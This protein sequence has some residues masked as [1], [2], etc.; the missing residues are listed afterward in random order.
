[1]VK[2]DRNVVENLLNSAGSNI[3]ATSLLLKY[4]IKDEQTINSI[5][6]LWYAIEKLIRA[7]LYI[8]N[9]L[10]LKKKSTSADILLTSLDQK[11]FNSN[12]VLKL[13]NDS[14]SVKEAWELLL[15]ATPNL[16]L[17]SAYF[18]EGVHI[19]NDQTHLFCTRPPALTLKKAKRDA[20]VIIQHLC[21]S[22]SAFAAEK[23]ELKG[24]DCTA[25][26]LFSDPEALR[27]L[28]NEVQKFN[29]RHEFEIIQEENKKLIA[30]NKHFHDL[31]QRSD[32]VPV[33]HYFDVNCPV[34]NEPNGHVGISIDENYRVDNEGDEA[35]WEGPIHYEVYFENFACDHC[36]ACVTSL[37]VLS[38]LGYDV[39]LITPELV[40]DWDINEGVQNITAEY[41][42]RK[43]FHM[44]S[45]ITWVNA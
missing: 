28:E 39:D 8:I 16:K 5:C 43:G 22:I 27:E 14:I 23:Q 25:K 17:L 36:G 38:D 6:N 13:H 24:F 11:A 37:S 42:D 32:I 12:Y 2:I 18:D 33:E 44:G 45:S 19:R 21:D 9:P 4:Q 3:D 29:L 40:I 26:R 7:N 41:P 31:L 10:L 20:W 35:W 15:D 30:K 34:C 1:M